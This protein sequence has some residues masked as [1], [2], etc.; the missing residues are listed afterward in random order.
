MQR[1]FVRVIGV[2]FGF[3]RRNL[4][5]G[6]RSLMLSTH[7]R[8]LIADRCWLIYD[9]IANTF[10]VP[11]SFHLEFPEIAEIAVASGYL[12]IRVQI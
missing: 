1:S 12:E 10:S 6:K 3:Y 8:Y 5:F 7:Q 2:I 9:F 11:D 4:P